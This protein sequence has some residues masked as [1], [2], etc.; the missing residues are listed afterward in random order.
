MLVQV[1]G[2]AMELPSGATIAALIPPLWRRV[3]NPRV[4]LWRRTFYPEIEDWRP[5]NKALNPPPR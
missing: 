4:R 2:E 1:N 5:Y 3:M